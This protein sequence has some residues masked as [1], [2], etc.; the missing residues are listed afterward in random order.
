MIAR[1]KRTGPAK[2]AMIR[3]WMPSGFCWKVRLRILASV[4]GF[5]LAIAMAGCSD[6][7]DFA[8]RLKAEIE[9][10][11]GTTVEFAALTD[12]KW[13]EV[14]VYGPYYPLDEIN[15]KHKIALQGELGFEHVAEG[16]CLYIFEDQG[17]TVRAISISRNAVSCSDILDPGVYS[18]RDAVFKVVQDEGRLSPHLSRATRDK[19]SNPTKRIQAPTVIADQRDSPLCGVGRDCAHTTI[20]GNLCGV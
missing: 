14:Y 6:S 5:A 7:D 3:H 17:K 20:R 11:V 18:N 2:K 15:R 13:T 19:L 10:G 12:F 1:T 8:R 16:E 9:K 4:A